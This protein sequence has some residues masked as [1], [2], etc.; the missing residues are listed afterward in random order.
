MEGARMNPLYQI[1]DWDRNFENNKSRE[2]EKCSFVCVPNK[3][4]GLGFTRIIAEKDGASI[5]GIWVMILQVC[6]RQNRPRQGFLTQ[7]GAQDG[8]RMGT[9]CL[10]LRLRRTSQ[11]LERALSVLSSEGVGWI[12]EINP[13]ETIEPK[14]LERVPAK[15][16]PSARPVP[17]NRREEKRNPFH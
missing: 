9:E 15:C 17:L 13:A 8:H 12:K 1:A 16:P 4:D 14:E 11:E 10:A 5:Y 6:S 2:R 7:N 3:H